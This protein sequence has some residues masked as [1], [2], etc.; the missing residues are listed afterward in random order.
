MSDLFSFAPNADS[1]IQD[2]NGKASIRK[3]A[4]AKVTRGLKR[5]DSFAE[6]MLS[7]NNELPKLDQALFI[8]TTGQSDTGGIFRWLLQNL[9]HIKELYIATWIISPQNI[10]CLCK[11]IDEGK[12][13]SLVFVAS[14]RMKEL[15]KAHH[16]QLITSFQERKGKIKFRVCNS[17]A[18]TFSL[19]DGK[20][21]YYTC[22]GSGNWTENPRIEA[23]T[24]ANLK[25]LFDFNKEW[26]S[27]LM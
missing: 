11:A 4:F 24:L 5:D 14:G 23:Y 19:S 20:G 21:N 8:K 6:L 22:E 18:K 3:G 25:E 10:E 1:I 15:K 17:H 9:G 13:D 16:N 7:I 2:N 27:E 26:M 12:I